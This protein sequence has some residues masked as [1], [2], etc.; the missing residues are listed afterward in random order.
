MYPWGLRLHR[1]RSKNWKKVKLEN[2]VTVY[3]GVTIKDNVFVGSHVAFTNDLYPRNLNPDW[4]ILPTLVKQGSSI[5]AGSVIVCGITL[6][7]NSLI[8]AG[9][10]VTNDI[11]P[12]GLAYG[13]PARVRGFVC[14]C[15]T[16]LEIKEK[17]KK[18]L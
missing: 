15:G 2:Q 7:E 8:G 9:S 16:K 3:E 6:G 17:K 13:N 14:K 5:G 12:F 18:L 10:V 1:E 11:P 4:K